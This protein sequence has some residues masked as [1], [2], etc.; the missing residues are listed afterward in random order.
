MNVLKYVAAATACVGECLLSAKLY[1]H[2]G[3]GSTASDSAAHV[4]LEPVH[5]APFVGVS[6]LI[7][8]ALVLVRRSK[9]RQAT[10]PARDRAPQK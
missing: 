9:T 8:M 10:Q 1:A 4:L 7:A 5:V 3:H 6:L 2:P